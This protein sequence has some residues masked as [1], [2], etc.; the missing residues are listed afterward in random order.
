MTL[1]RQNLSGGLVCQPFEPFVG[2]RQSAVD[3]TAGAGADV[4]AVLQMLGLA[5]GQRRR[6]GED[7]E[8]LRRFVAFCSV[9]ISHGRTPFT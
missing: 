4:E 8:G 6:A 7:G 3:L 5:F 1:I 2:A 9:P